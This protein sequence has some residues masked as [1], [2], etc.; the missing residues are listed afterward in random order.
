MA[1]D[2]SEGREPNRYLEAIKEGYNAVGLAGAVALSAALMNP[3]PLL[4]GL[5]AEAAYIAFVP[6]SKWYEARVAARYDGAVRERREQI[7][8]E[9]LPTLRPVLQAR[10]VTLEN[11][12]EAIA[13]Q[14]QSDPKFFRQIGRKLDYLL[15]KWLQ[16]AGR[17]SH[18]N[19]YLQNAAREAGLKPNS[20][21]DPVAAIQASFEKEA[22]Q[23]KARAEAEQ[24][25]GTRSL[26]ESRGQVLERRREWVGRLAKLRSDLS[27]QLQ[28]IEDTFALVQDQIRARA[29]EMVLADLENVIWQ[30]NTTAELLNEFG[31]L[32]NTG[33]NTSGI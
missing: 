33:A 6:D 20:N 30:S 8:R 11:L 32:E 23:L 24:S 13:Q 27:H 16:F 4:I 3:I 22:A 31:T 10:W 21:A 2:A 9:V 15:E 12:R 18:F 28:L 19:T 26:L 14:G 5:V 29:P 1:P 25:Y 17:E 7:K